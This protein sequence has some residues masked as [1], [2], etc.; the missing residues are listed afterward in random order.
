MD[1]QIQQWIQ[2]VVDITVNTKVKAVEE[3][4]DAALAPVLKRLE[5][6]ELQQEQSHNNAP[7]MAIENTVVASFGRSHP[8]SSQTASPRT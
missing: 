3:R 5:S 7:Q 1:C 8:I 2:E 4:L 6:L